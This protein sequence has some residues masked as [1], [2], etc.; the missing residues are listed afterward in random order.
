MRRRELRKALM[1]TM[2]E[3][4]GVMSLEAFD[5]GAQEGDQICRGVV[6]ELQRQD[7]DR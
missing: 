7:Y 6:R 4:C 1:L 5:E 3:F 2:Q